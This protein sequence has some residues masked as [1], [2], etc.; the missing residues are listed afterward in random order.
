MT[1]SKVFRSGNSQAVRIPRELH[2]PY[3]E[4]EITRR[5]RELV[6]TPLPR[7]DGR[8]VF[9]ALT[10]FEGMPEREQPAEQERDPL[11]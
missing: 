5:G 1:R 4:V 9:A 3:G 10:A 7:Q 2:L 11:L 8:A 6:I